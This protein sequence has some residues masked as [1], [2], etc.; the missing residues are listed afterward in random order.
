[1]ASKQTVTHY[2]IYVAGS[3]IRRKA[4]WYNNPYNFHS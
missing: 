2:E 3:F 4:Y 1:M